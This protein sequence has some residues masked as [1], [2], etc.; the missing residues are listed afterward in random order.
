MLILDQGLNLQNLENNIGNLNLGTGSTSNFNTRIDGSQGNKVDHLTR[1]NG[2]HV[3]FGKNMDVVDKGTVIA[4][5]GVGNV[6]GIIKSG[7]KDTDT[8]A[9]LAGGL[10]DS[11]ADVIGIFNGKKLLLI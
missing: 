3:N 10:V 8:T 11:V 5:G 6:E 1:E 2:A 4:Q 7:L 9:K